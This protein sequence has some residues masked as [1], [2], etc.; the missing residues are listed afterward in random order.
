MIL[1]NMSYKQ[2]FKNKK[3]T[4][5]GLGL[6]GRGLADVDFLAEC[7]ADLIVTDLKNA[8]DLAPTLKK[9][10]KFRKIKYVLGE[11]RLEDF[12][13]R[14]MVL[15]SAGVPID[16]PFIA[17][18]RAQGIPIEMDES[19]FAKLAPDVTL[20]GVTGTRG[21]TTT[22]M[23]IYEMLLHAKKKLKWKHRIFLG[24]NIR[25]LATLPL[26]KKVK[27]GDFLVLELSSWQLQGFGEAG[28]SPHISVFTNFLDDHLNYYNGS[29][30]A[31]W[32]DKA[33]IFSS[34]TGDDYLV[35]PIEMLKDIQVK[36]PSLRSHFMVPISV[37]DS[38]NLK[39]KGEHNK[40]N[41]DMVFAV[42][43]ILKI[44]E[45]LIKESFEK[46]SGVEGR[47]Q[48]V[49]EI[50]GISIYND[51]TST[52]PDSLM[53]ALEAL[54][55]EKNVVLIMGGADKNLDMTPVLNRITDFATTVILLSG[56]GTSGSEKIKPLLKSLDDV[57][58]VEV[59]SITDALVQAFFYAR[60]GDIILFS[61][62]FASFGMF[63]NEFDRGDQFDKAVKEL[64]A[65]T[66]KKNKKK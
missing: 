58:I 39:I 37:P 26:L 61:P 65:D 40:R 11:H 32:D 49:A 34:Q 23:L 12:R 25:G 53:V 2:Y 63:K 43:E 60:S 20:V 44:D 46:F 13:D 24:G 10:K 42:G 22:T 19:L 18:A 31:Y 47:Q 17:E 8:E 41:A 59:E 3:I 64:T 9:L 14:D 45:K 21:K 29:R 1:F 5:M 28:I 57:H 48:L 4:V 62:G 52:T 55:G 30:E 36:Y 6:L 35:A 66:V 38:W 50:G 7:G 56:V 33:K 27:A 15:K 51:T 16:S 54:G